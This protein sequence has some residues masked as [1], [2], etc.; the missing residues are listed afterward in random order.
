MHSRLPSDG[1]YSWPP[2][3]ETANLLA[4]GPCCFRF[5]LTSLKFEFVHSI[6]SGLRDRLNPPCLR[7]T[8]VYRITT[9]KGVRG[10][11]Y[12]VTVRVDQNTYT[13]LATMPPRVALD[14]VSYRTDSRF[15]NTAIQR[16]ASY[17][18][19]AQ[20]PAHQAERWCPGLFQRAYR[21][22]TNSCDPLKQCIFSPVRGSP[23]PCLP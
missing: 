17:Q 6:M 2:L 18:T 1:L 13:A 7:R 10:H 11:R 22:A 16:V 19:P 20:R 8:G 23:S 14:Q 4:V 21:A 9:I 3:C 15:Q 12:Q 5:L